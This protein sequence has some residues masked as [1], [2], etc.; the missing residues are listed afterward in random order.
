[1]AKA[2]KMKKYEKYYE[3]IVPEDKDDVLQ[4]CM[5]TNQSLTRNLYMTFISN[6]NKKERK[7]GEEQIDVRF[8]ACVFSLTFDAILAK[9][10]SLESKKSSAKINIANRFE[11]GFDTTEDEDDEKNGNYMIFIRDKGTTKLTDM[12]LNPRAKPIERA[13][14]WI[15]ANI[16]DDAELLKEIATDA[17]LRID[18]LDII[19]SSSELIMPIFVITYESLVSY[20]KI[21]RNEM[22]ELDYE[23]NFCS[24]FNIKSSESEEGPDKITIRPNINSKLFLKDDEKAS[25]D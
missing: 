1:M 18:K 13:V 19:L 25:G 17:K 24:C 5:N 16:T 21:R 12:M 2:K 4:I 14:E 3:S 22:N 6:P 10:K 8:I 15:N 7:K 20:L 11:I 23:I 9:L